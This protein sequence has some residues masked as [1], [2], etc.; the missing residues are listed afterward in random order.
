[1]I[2]TLPW[3]TLA[4]LPE[5]V[6]ETWPKVDDVRTTGVLRPKSGWFN[7]LKAS[8]RRFTDR[9]S[10]MGNNRETCESSWKKGGV[11]KAFL[12]IFP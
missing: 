1:V 10:W 4:A 6:D 2:F 5:A 12:P 3:K 7:T 8:K 9:F 11:R